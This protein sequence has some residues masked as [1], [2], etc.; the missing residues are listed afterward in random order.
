MNPRIVGGVAGDH[1][2]GWG[3]VQDVEVFG[4]ALTQE[5]R[6]KSGSTILGTLAAGATVGTKLQLNFDCPKGAQL[7]V[8]LMNATDRVVVVSQGARAG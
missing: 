5:V 2:L 1:V 4:S 8:Q 6:V 7:A 3:L